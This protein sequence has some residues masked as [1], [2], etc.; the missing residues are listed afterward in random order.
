VTAIAQPTFPARTVR[1]RGFGLAAL[2]SD[3]SIALIRLTL[4]AAVIAIYLSS[5][6]IR[7]ALGSGAVAVLVLATVYAVVSL[8]LLA[9]DEQPSYRIRVGTLLA[10]V[11]LITMWIWATGGAR[12]E[13]WT[14]YLIVIASSALRFR[15]V[16]TLVVALS[17]TVLDAGLLLADGLAL[18]ELIHRSAAMI[19]TGFAAGVLSFQRTEHRHERS[20]LQQLAE[21][22]SQQLGR[23]RAEIERLRRVDTKRSEFVAIAAHEFRTPL[24]AIIGV[25]STLKVHG[26]VLDD[27]VREELID[28]ASTQAER[29]ARL[30]DDLL[31]VSRIEDG[32]LRLHLEAVDVPTLIS[33][34]A[35]ASG[36]AGRVHVEL[37]RAAPVLCDADAVVRVLTN[38][39]DNARKYS[40]EDARIVLGVSQ[41]GGQVRFAVRDG[42]PGIEPADREAVFERFRRLGADGKAGAGLGLYISRGLVEAHGGEM[43]VAEAPEGGAE[44]SFTLPVAGPE[45]NV[46]QVTAGLAASH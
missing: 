10:D 42:G 33:D 38:L 24:A 20:L 2:Q 5:L 39:L 40:P 19:A 26:K 14:L 3:R 21:T 22:R 9:G 8:V 45:A 11:S 25:L 7:H 12:S 29:L 41:D 28:G 15:V 6:G 31:T 1:D 18:D 44:F 46:T 35:H 30:V 43:R 4:V 17:I 13:F 36:T 23:E 32:V 37:H 34:A 27:D 16:E